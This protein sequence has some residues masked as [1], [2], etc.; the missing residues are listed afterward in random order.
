L[1]EKNWKKKK[2]D[3]KKMP[4]VCFFKFSTPLQYCSPNKMR[5]ETANTTQR[6]NYIFTVLAPTKI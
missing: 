5:K 1:G 3:E 2:K 6:K 4:K